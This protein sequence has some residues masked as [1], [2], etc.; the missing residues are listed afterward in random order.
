MTPGRSRAITCID[1][2]LR[3]RYSHRCELL[4]GA[5]RDYFIDLLLKEAGWPLDQSR[6]REFEVAGMANS[7][8][9]GFVDYVL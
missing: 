2:G 7:K 9:K 6:D 3:F 1:R 5:T 4:R 8:G